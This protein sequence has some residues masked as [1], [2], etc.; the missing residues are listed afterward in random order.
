MLR[1]STA[2]GQ[3]GAPDLARVCHHAPWSTQ[4][5]HAVHWPMS[6]QQQVYIC[7]LFPIHY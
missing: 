2:G 7:L 3:R 1:P 5:T 6:E 4:G